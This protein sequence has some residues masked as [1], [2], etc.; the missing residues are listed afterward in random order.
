MKKRREISQ[1]DS[2]IKRKSKGLREATLLLM[3]NK[4][5]KP[6]YLVSKHT[7]SDKMSL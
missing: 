6:E 7:E 5:G 2:K 3:N 4:V 1:A